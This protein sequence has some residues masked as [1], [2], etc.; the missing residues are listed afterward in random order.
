M[1]ARE[2][3][4]G[5]VDWVS[6]VV[7]PCEPAN[8]IPLTVELTVAAAKESGMEFIEAACAAGFDEK[9]SNFERIVPISFVDAKKRMLYGIVFRANE[10]VEKSETERYW[11][12]PTGVRL[13]M[14]GFAERGMLGQVDM[15]HNCKKLKDVFVAEQGIVLAGDPRFDSDTDP[16][17]ENVDAWWQG[18]KVKETPGGDKIIAMA[19]EGKLRGF[20]LKGTMAC[21][22]E[23]DVEFTKGKEKPEMTK[24]VG[25]DSGKVSLIKQA[26][27]AVGQ[28][29]ATALSVFSDKIDSV[30]DTKRL[31]SLFNMFCDAHWAVMQS[32]DIDDKE[33]ALV[34]CVDDY[35]A[36][37][38][39]GTKVEM[40]KIG[41]RAWDKDESHVDA[42]LCASARGVEIDLAGRV[43]SKKNLEQM[44]AAHGVLGKLIAQAEK[45]E[46][47]EDGDGGK[48]TEMTTKQEGAEMDKVQVTELVG[49]LLAEALKPLTEGLAALK[50]AIPTELKLSE[51]DAAKLGKIDAIE[52]RLTAAEAKAA[53]APATAEQQVAA[54]TTKI[55]AGTV[56]VT[57]LT[58]Q[59]ETQKQEIVDLTAQLK[60]LGARRPASMSIPGGESDEGGGAP[61]VKPEVKAAAGR[62]QGVIL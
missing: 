56:K 30:K 11:S 16:H 38:E 9:R 27:S 12:S 34:E 18:H 43:F 55:E 37:I 58:G 48:G 17:P 5:N 23:E 53:E 31:Q 39:D 1:K 49:G 62:P 35:K 47:G 32:A 45:V 44:K 60:K 13:M 52:T 26:A 42:L 51:A 19:L 10:I 29:V 54:L 6:L 61:A 21:G 22:P 36:A 2:F 28:A 40:A 8:R 24:K 4:G 41:G 50:S 3:I 33:A 46:G 20:S 25:D 59:I 57:E 7:D 14:E 15:N